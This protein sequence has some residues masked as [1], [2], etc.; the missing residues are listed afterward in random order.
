MLK[1]G[2]GF[3]DSGVGGLSVLCE[4]EKKLKEIPF[5]YYGDNRRAPYGD[6]S[7][8]EIRAY[9]CEAFSFFQKVGALAV[10]IACNTV[11]ALLIDELRTLFSFPIVGVEPAVLP[12]VKNWDRVLVLSTPATSRSSRL[13]DLIQRAV[14]RFPMSEIE[15]VACPNLAFTVERKYPCDRDEIFA[16][17]PKR[18]VDCVVLGCTHYSF[19]KSEIAEFY[20][21][22]VID[23]N[24][25]VASRLKEVM[26]EIKNRAKNDEKK[27]GK[28]C[29]ILEKTQSAVLLSGLSFFGAK[30]DEKRRGFRLKKV[31]LADRAQSVRALYFV[32]SG[33]F[34]N[35]TFYERLFTFRG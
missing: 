15:S 23:G 32:G 14:E 6:K 10:V 5:Y 25:G 30:K 31:A 35:R 9:A 4:C 16:Q 24:R 27:K 33:R 21:A 28:T 19:L 17:L 34:F 22:E 13:Q 29:G 11:T 12:A 8:N 2:I 26:E 3:F 7:I 1:G 18:K 20:K